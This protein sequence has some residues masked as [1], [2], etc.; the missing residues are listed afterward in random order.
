[1]NKIVLIGLFIACS[2]YLN[3][4]CRNKNFNQNDVKVDS[5]LTF[6]FKSV[7][8]SNYKV[9][10]IDSINDYYLIYISKEK[11]RYKVI[12]KKSIER[13]CDMIRLGKTY[14]WQVTEIFGTI[15][16]GVFKPTCLSMDDKTKICLEDSITDLCYAENLKG[17]CI[18]AIK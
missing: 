5:S 11:E 14:N 17:L 1:M 10:K 4:Q 2:C 6:T 12:S 7:S 13:S 15:A 8:K 16:G 9:Y 3:L 18:E